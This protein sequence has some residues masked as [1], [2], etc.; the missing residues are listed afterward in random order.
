MAVLREFHEAVGP[1]IFD[2]DGTIAQFTGDGMSVFFHDPV[3]RDDPSWNAVQLPSTCVSAPRSCPR[4]GAVGAT[5]SRSASESRSVSP[6]VARS[7]SRAAR[8]TPRSA[9]W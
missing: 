8:S 5:N 2:Y 9:P 3:K 1:M 4:H 6:R 7:G